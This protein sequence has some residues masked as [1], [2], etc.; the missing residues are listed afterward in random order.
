MPNIFIS[1]FFQV[2]QT[3]HLGVS[4]ACP[5]TTLGRAWMP[6]MPGTQ[7]GVRNRW[8][9]CTAGCSVA[10]A[11]EKSNGA[12][13]CFKLWIYIC[14]YLTLRSV[15][16]KLLIPPIYRDF[17]LINIYIYNIPGGWLVS[18]VWGVDPIDVFHP[19]STGSQGYTFD[20]IRFNQSICCFDLSLGGD[21][22]QKR[23]PRVM[24]QFKCVP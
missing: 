16:K 9:G 21:L 20:A 7:C 18:W 13:V 4:I 1:L 23:V 2:S 11:T 6:W 22:W 10:S 24:K 3:S 19:D 15:I 8:H 5:S 12:L 17:L 14:L